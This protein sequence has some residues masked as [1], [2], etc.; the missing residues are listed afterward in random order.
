MGHE[1]D[2]DDD[3]FLQKVAEKRYEGV[4]VDSFNYLRPNE[5]EA[6]PVGENGI[7]NGDII[8]AGDRYMVFVRNDPSANDSTKNGVLNDDDLVL[9]AWNDVVKQRRLIAILKE[10]DMPKENIEIWRLNK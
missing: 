6:I 4:M 9:D 7:L 1:V 3:D 5:N 8:K 10:E 2:Y